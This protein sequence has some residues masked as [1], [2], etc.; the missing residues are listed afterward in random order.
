MEYI[1]LKK[2]TKEPLNRH[3]F[4]NNIDELEDAAIVLDNYKD[5]VFIDFDGLKDNKNCEDRIIKGI[6]ET[7]P[8]SLV[9][10][11]TRGKHLY[12]KT[13]RKLKQWTDGFL[14]ISVQCDGKMGNAYAVIKQNGIVRNHIGDLSFDTLTDLPDILL[15]MYVGKD[16]ENLCGLK[17]GQGRHNKL[18]RHLC[19]VKANYDE[20]D[21]KGIA[22]FINKYVFDDA[23]SDEELN[24]IIKSSLNYDIE[25][26]VKE[27]EQNYSKKARFINSICKE[28]T[29]K[30]NI[31]IADN[32]IYYK[33]NNRYNS[34]TKKLM[35]LIYDEYEFT[36][37]EYEEILFQLRVIG[38]KEQQEKSI[39]ALR[40][41]AIVDGVFVQN[42]EEFSSIYLD[43]NYNE[44]AYDKEVDNFLQFITSNEES[45]EKN[46]LRLVIEEMIG[47]CLMTKNF[48]HKIFLLVGNGAN[49]KSTLLNTLF[50]L[51]GNSATNVPIK[52]LERDDY[53]ARL[54][55]KL[56]NIS[57]DVDFNYIKSSQN[58]KTLASGDIVVGRELYSKPYTFKNKATMIFS[59]NELVVFADKTYGMERRLC[60]IP[61]ENKVKKT[62][63]SII[64]RLTSDNSK[65]YLLKLGLE[66]MKRI[67]N[68]KY[69]LTNSE[70]INIVIKNYL[71]ENDS[72]YS[73][74]E[75]GNVELE[76][77][78]F[79]EV[80]TKYS[81]YCDENEFIPYKKNNFSR[82]LKTRGYITKIKTI[83]GKSL[84]VLVKEMSN[85]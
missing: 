70:I 62:D 85:Q 36:R 22:E 47:H 37:G 80:Y 6:L 66:G 55:N 28:I 13:K 60:I 24:N 83:N 54:T 32:Q 59:M 56:V 11:T 34:D 77:Q 29:N 19:Q 65:S 64:D 10:E 35:E 49:G 81:T 30:Y 14:N 26:V 5:V 31:H 38:K 15:P 53:V 72:V 27:S 18:L 73:F 67:V 82:K 12:Y 9:V 25:A 39:I 40:N 74:I 16:I 44:N 46:D 1:K 23:L 20:V 58:I 42:C 45:T 84:R 2:G 57:D 4:Y 50:S 7:Y 71:A 52:R 63:P 33:D 79:S 78:P 8:C 51:F 3:Q 43:V 61:F 17:D 76:E 41:G 21:I 75:Y 48:P 69:Q 68:N